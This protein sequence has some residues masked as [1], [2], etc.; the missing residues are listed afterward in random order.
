MKS[1]V[2]RKSGGTVKYRFNREKLPIGT[3]VVHYMV[4]VE[5]NGQKTQEIPVSELEAHP[6]KY[7][8]MFPQYIDKIKNGNPVVIKVL[9]SEFKVKDGAVVKNTPKRTI[10]DVAPKAAVSKAV[11][12]KQ[13]DPKLPEPDADKTILGGADAGYATAETASK[14]KK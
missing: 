7:H 9:S 1:I 8:T 13:E 14:R 10:K 2:S 11:E 4:P 6:A 12:E 3:D 5:V